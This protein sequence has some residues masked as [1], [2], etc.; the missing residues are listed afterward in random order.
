M[1]RC[2]RCNAENPAKAKFCLECGSPLTLAETAAPREP[3]ASGEAERRQLTCLFCDLVSSVELSE[4]LD[5]EELRETLADYHRVCA[6]VVRRFE[7][8]IHDYSGDGMMVYFGFPSAHEDD[9]QRAVRSGLGIVEAV[10]QLNSRV[11]AELGIELHVRIGIDTGLVVAGAIDADEGMESTAAIGVTPNIA[12]RLQALAAPDSVV[13]SAAAYRLIA[14]YFDCRELGFKAIR[15]IS[16]PMAIYRVLHES[17]ARTRLDVAAQR[18]L[19]PMQGR[20][21]EFGRL[22]ERW[23]GARTGHGGVALVAGEPGIGKSRL[24]WALQQ[25]VAQS[26]DAYLVRLSCS[27]YFTN[28]AFYPIVQLL[29]RVL[30]LRPDDTVS[31]RLDKIEGL[32]AQYGLE[33]PSVVPLVAKLLAVPFEDRYAPL[34]LPADRQRQLTID[35]LVK[36]ALMRAN[37]QPVLF[38]VEDLHWIDPSSLDLLTQL[39]EGVGRNRQLVVLSFRPEFAPPWPDGPGLERLDLNRL[40]RD[41]SERIVTEVAG[42]P[43]PAE[44][45]SQLVGKADGVP[46]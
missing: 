25:H 3:A 35:A 28:T 44:L 15:G 23:A 14:G 20:D 5:P 1:V 4:R 34:D 9:A 33:L 31:Q 6:T 19:P 17:G 27:P 11:Q 40:D 21:G 43:V 36:I 29:E 22:A 39:I 8:H 12:A 24:I 13:V 18:G 41:A 38:V 32:L 46:L 2:S 26:P 10:R 37:Y 42:M 16:Q 30:E 45:V 7:G